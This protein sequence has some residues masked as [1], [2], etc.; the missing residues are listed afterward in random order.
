MMAF[1][2]LL[3]QL[4]LPF[5][6]V[7]FFV[8]G[9]NMAKD[10]LFKLWLGSVVGYMAE[11]SNSESFHNR[12]ISLF[13]KTIIISSKFISSKAFNNSFNMLDKLIMICR[14]KCGVGLGY[15]SRILMPGS[16]RAS[17]PKEHFF[18]SNNKSLLKRKKA[19]A[20]TH[21]PIEKCHQ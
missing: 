10:D 8:I 11:K 5:Q 4:L 1:L 7:L 16:L 14:L 3:D 2:D 17:S 12:L 9:K 20:S 21:T 13:F 15:N 19:T 18:V 6:G